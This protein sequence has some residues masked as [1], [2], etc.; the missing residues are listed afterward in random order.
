[1]DTNPT[2]AELDEQFRFYDRAAK[3]YALMTQSIKYTNAIS[4]SAA[5]FTGLATQLPA[6]VPGALAAVAAILA[7]VERT[8]HPER[9]WIRTRTSAEQLR[10]ERTFYDAG[11]GEYAD[12]TSRQA[13]LAE[14]MEEIRS[15]ERTEYFDQL[16]SSRPPPP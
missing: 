8:T 4:A 7:I 10:R 1:M 11:V 6:V 13:L 9:E 5:A 12:P 15:R 16:S 2:R 14:R 3:R